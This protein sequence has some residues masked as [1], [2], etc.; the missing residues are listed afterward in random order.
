MGS[1][2]AG[3]LSHLA[4]ITLLG[5][6]EAQINI[7]NTKGLTLIHPDGRTSQHPT[8]ATNDPATIETA[9]LLLIMVKT[10]NT[11]AAAKNAAAILSQDGLAITLQ[12]GLGNLE[13]IAGIIGPERA[14]QGVTSEG[15]AMLGPGIVRHAGAGQSYLAE[16]VMGTQVVDK[17]RAARLKEVANLFNE[18]GFETQLVKNADSL[19][20]GKLA[21]NAGINPL[22]AL[23]QV[24]N[25]FLLENDDAHWLMSRAAAEVSA[26]AQALEIPLP[27]ADAAERAA[28]VAQATAANYSS[29]AQDAT[30]GVPTEIEAICGA[31]VQYGQ[32]IGLPTP[33]NHTLQELI[34][35]Q[36]TTGQWHDSIPDQPP[37]IRQRLARLAARN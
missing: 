18:A 1:L 2:F 8:K 29:M 36:T 28:Q 25:G 26:V 31:V 11:A 14:A 10:P 24:P 30:R 37:D 21:V 33:V 3:R 35:R 34:Q 7:L 32:R 23:L 12:N 13:T 19:I 16:S 4:D 6:W 9:D 15:A 27:Y 20:W 5:N 17:S 22:T